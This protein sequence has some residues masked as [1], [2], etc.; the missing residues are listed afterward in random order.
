VKLRRVLARRLVRY[1][2]I[3]LLIVGAL[4]LLPGGRYGATSFLLLAVASLVV[5]AAL[6]ER[7]WAARRSGRGPGFRGFTPGQSLSVGVAMAALGLAMLV[8]YL[9]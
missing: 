3:Y 7:S 2:I 1:P 4:S 5:G 8:L 9:A 6:A